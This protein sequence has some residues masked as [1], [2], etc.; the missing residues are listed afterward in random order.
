MDCDK[1]PAALTY[2]QPWS[3]WRRLGQVNHGGAR[4]WP[5][6]IASS[7]SP[8]QLH[9][10]AKQK[11]HNDHFLHSHNPNPKFVETMTKTVADEPMISFRDADFQLANSSLFIA[12]AVRLIVNACIVNL[13]E[14]C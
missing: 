2:F 4:D 13:T 7:G 3:I 10:A 9:R 12:E 5:D 1:L 6:T 14:N 11:Q 8:C